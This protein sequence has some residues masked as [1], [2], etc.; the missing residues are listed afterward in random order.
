[1]KDN[2]EHDNFK[3]MM[4]FDNYMKHIKTV[5]IVVYNSFLI[6]NSDEFKINN[7]SY[8]NKNYSAVNALDKIKNINDYV[9]STI[10]VILNEIMKQV[11]NCISNSQRIQKIYYEQLIIE[12]EEKTYTKYMSFFIDVPNNICDQPS[13]IKVYPLLIRP[14][15]K[16]YSFDFKFD[17]IF[18]RK[19]GSNENN[20]LGVATLKNG[21]NANEFY[22]IYE[23]KPCEQYDYLYYTASF[24]D[25]YNKLQNI[26]M[27]LLAM[28]GK[29]I[30]I[31]EGNQEK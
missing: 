24:Q 11:P 31:K 19:A 7:F 4:A 30:V 28:T 23:V 2:K 27:N 20:I 13:E 12:N 17:K 29:S 5:P 6:G 9:L 1:M 8:R 18:I 14:D 25:T 21:I 10:D 3:Y 15:N 26:K 16:I 22:R